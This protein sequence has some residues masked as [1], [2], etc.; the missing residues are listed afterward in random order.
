MIM[1]HTYTIFKCIE[2]LC[3]SKK[4]YNFGRMGDSKCRV[5]KMFI[6]GGIGPKLYGFV[7]T[8]KIV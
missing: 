3:T 6:K 2:K 7:C 1:I 4:T 8:T 5:K